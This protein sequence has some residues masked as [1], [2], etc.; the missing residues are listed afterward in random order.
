MAGRG[1]H[2]TAVRVNRRWLPWIALAVVAV[3]MIVVLVVRSRPDQSPT[4]R[5][6]RL[7][8]SLACPVCEG[9]SVADSNAPESR[10]IREKINVLIAQHQSDGEIRAYFVGKYGERILL[11]P[12]NQGIGLLAWAIPAI[13]LLVGAVGIAL[14]LRRWSRTPRLTATPEDEAIVAAAREQ[15]P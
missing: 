9:Q 10:A 5:A 11:A 4:A 3:A 13:A 2:R 1:A 12:N 8:H 6:T 15:A 14:A 7:A